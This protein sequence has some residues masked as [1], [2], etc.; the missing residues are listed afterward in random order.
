MAR[1]ME[2]IR[3]RGNAKGNSIARKDD[4]NARRQASQRAELLE[5]MRGKMTQRTKT[6]RPDWIPATFGDNVMDVHKVRNGLP[7]CG[8]DV[9]EKPEEWRRAVNCPGCLESE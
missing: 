8:M 7:L 2:R 6:Q 4:E 3:P 5:R 9:S 1:P